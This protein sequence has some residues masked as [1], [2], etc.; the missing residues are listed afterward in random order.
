MEIVNKSLSV[1]K[2]NW[3]GALAGA[4]VGFLVAKKLIKT[5]KTWVKVVSVLVGV[6]AG[7]TVQSKFF[8]KKG[9]PTAATVT[10]K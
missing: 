3:I 7:G 5:E 2:N 9:S 10:K 1:V 4:G 6:I 8:A